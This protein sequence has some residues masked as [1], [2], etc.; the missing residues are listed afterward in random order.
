LL[1][2]ESAPTFLRQGW[3]GLGPGSRGAGVP[4]L[5]LALQSAVASRELRREL[6]LF[7]RRL[8]EQ[9][10]SLVHAAETVEYLYLSAIRDRV[11]PPRRLAAATHSMTHL[12]A[13]KLQRKYRRWAGTATTDDSNDRSQIAAILS[14]G[15]ASQAAP[16][17]DQSET[18]KPAL[19]LRVPASV[20]GPH[21]TNA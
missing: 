18:E 8:V 2:P 9:R 19:P 1:T 5:L 15:A 10:F 13:Y 17:N 14:S 11:S 21:K 12:A 16:A 7:G 6:G 20:A 3:Y 4:A